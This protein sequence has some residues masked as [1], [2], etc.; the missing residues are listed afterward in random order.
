M[1]ATPRG[2]GLKTFSQSWLGWIALA[3]IALLVLAPLAFPGDRDYE[4]GDP[5]SPDT[6]GM[7][8]VAKV[9][10]QM[11]VNTSTKSA[12]RNLDVDSDTTLVLLH[13]SSDLFTITPELTEAAARAGRVV[14]FGMSDDRIEEFGVPASSLDVWGIDT[15]VVTASPICKPYVG[16]AHRIE[17]TEQRSFIEPTPDSGDIIT[18]FEGSQGAFMHVWPANDEHPEFVLVEDLSIFTNSQITIY[19]HAALALALFGAHPN[20]AFYYPSLDF[21][22]SPAEQGLW[23]LLPP[24]A[25]WAAGMLLIAAA[26]LMVAKGRRLGPLASEPLP[27][28]V[29]ASEVEYARASLAREGKHVQW[30]LGLLQSKARRELMR[31]LYLPSGAD[32]DTLL[33][34][35][36]T[37]VNQPIDRLR[38][39]LYQ[40]DIS[41][42][43]ELA[44]R[45]KELD[46]LIQEVS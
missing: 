5:D 17:A 37:R 28:V 6:D 12:P 31:A 32:E 19:D 3:L 27:V 25:Y 10:E 18:C 30:T 9:L 40:T 7:K 34:A 11:G 8:A 1:S 16:R 42:E 22:P 36:A 2:M 45:V 21:L 33:S 24:W 41:T 23:G 4:A 20:A 29:N 44:K 14:V 26:A 35:L 46:N 39:L 43:Q 38:A 13:D 15:E